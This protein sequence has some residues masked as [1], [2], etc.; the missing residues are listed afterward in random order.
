M[1]ALTLILFVIFSC[2]LMY[3]I[4]KFSINYNRV[5]AEQ[6]FCS[7]DSFLR[8]KKILEELEQIDKEFRMGFISITNKGLVGVTYYVLEAPIYDLDS[9]ILGGEAGLKDFLRNSTSDK[10]LES[11]LREKAQKDADEAFYRTI[12]GDDFY[13]ERNKYKFAI[14]SPF[15]SFA[16]SGGNIIVDKD[17]WKVCPGKAV[18]T[19]SIF[20]SSNARENFLAPYAIESVAKEVF[21]YANIKRDPKGYNVIINW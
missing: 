18:Y 15:E 10:L 11:K 14:Y 21:S 9:I 1:F 4:N 8:L 19:C 17:Y 5:K 13:L 16:S 7:D 6:R 20:G 12:F 3:F 2:L